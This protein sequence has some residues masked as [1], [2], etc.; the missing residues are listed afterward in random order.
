VEDIKVLV[1]DY[2]PRRSL[3]LRYTDPTDGRQK[4]KSAKTRSRKEALKAAGQW[5]D[6]LRNGR[7]HAAS[8]MTWQDFRQRYENEVLAGLADGTDHKAQG[9]FNHV[10]SILNPMLLRHLT[11]QRISYLQAELRNRGRSKA[12]IKGILAHLGAALRWAAKMKLIPTAPV[13]ESPKRAKGSTL[14]KGRPIVLEEFERM[15]AAV[16]RVVDAPRKLPNGA[17]AASLHRAA[18]WRH[19]LRGLWLSGLRLGESLDLTWER[20]D[21]GLYVDLSG[22]RPMLRISADAEKGNKDRLLPCSPEF[23]EFLLATPEVERVGYV[24]NPLA[25]HPC[26]GSRLGNSQTGRTISAIGRAAGVKVSDK[27]F[28]SAHDLRRS[29]GE[30]WASRVMPQVLM[31]LMRHE[32]IET[33]LRFY[34]GKNAERTADVLWAAHEQAQTGNTSATTEQQTLQNAGNSVSFS[35]Y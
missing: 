9:V 13:I 5:Q 16:E 29:F 8:T 18:S 19:Y 10:E 35:G 15:L 7:Y 12:T 20:N 30:R 27:K 23:A 32:S 3:M 33:T 17:V 25:E 24:F 2:G 1:V 31:E 34:V 6:E 11:E 4:T 28:A 14:M 22:R 26:G 21:D